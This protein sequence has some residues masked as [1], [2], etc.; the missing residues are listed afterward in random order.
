[1]RIAVTGA[2]GHVGV[3]L[4]KSLVSRGFDVAILVRK[5]PGAFNG[6]D[7][8]QVKGD[9]LL[10]DSLVDL[11]KDAD[12]VIHLAALI[13]VG[14]KMNG[15]VVAINVD[16]TKNIVT[17]AR[18]SGVRKFIHFSSVDTLVH[19]P[20]N[21]VMDETRPISNSTSNP[22][23]YTKAIAEKWVLEQ[24]S[25]DF[26]VVV[27]NPSVIVGPEDL[28]PSL[29][30]SF[31]CDAITGAIPGVIPGGYDFVDVRDVVNATINSIEKGRG[32][33][34]YIISGRWVSVKE[35]S[36]LLADV[37]GAKRKLPVYPLWLAKLGIPFLYMFSKLKGTQPIYN[38]ESLSI[39][40]SS[41]RKISAHKA[42]VE[43][44]F[45]S[46]PLVETLSDT[47]R[48]FKENNYF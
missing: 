47:Y 28:G 3:N 46:R 33:E 11:C 10:P 26:D 38:S 14:S 17:V 23:E 22:Y 8:K 37:S 13:T 24:Q 5:N 12:V 44:D 4:V 25:K 1:M 34:K 31:I 39:L 43:L 48:W 45:H 16:G 15:G 6:L 32:G 9:V 42:K 18:K 40:Q 21:E 36:D 41:N 20:I 19:K 7:V 35:V 30:G 27:L 2:T 29:M